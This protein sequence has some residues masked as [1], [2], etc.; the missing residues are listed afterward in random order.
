MKTKWIKTSD[1]LPPITNKY[2]FEKNYND[3]PLYVLAYTKNKKM[4]IAS[5]EKWTEDEEP[6]WYDN[7]SEHW[8]LKD[9][10]IYWQ[11]LPNIPNNSNNNLEK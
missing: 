8:N 9:E 10:V 3:E 11:K 1:K 7:S 4:I 2:C 5:L 6:V